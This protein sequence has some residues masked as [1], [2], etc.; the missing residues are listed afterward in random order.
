MTI[1]FKA[2]E[3]ST[4]SLNYAVQD[5]YIL[6]QFLSRYMLRGLGKDNLVPRSLSL[7]RGEK[8]EDPG[9][10]SFCVEIKRRE[11]KISCLGNKGG[12]EG[13]GKKRGKLP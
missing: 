4:F 2:T 13:S 7:P 12:L 6:D 9:N 11:E 8:R 3:L 1:Q 10:E 5:A